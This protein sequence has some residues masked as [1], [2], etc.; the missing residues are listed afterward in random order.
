MKSVRSK[1]A[2]RFISSLSASLHP[3]IRRHLSFVCRGMGQTEA[4]RKIFYTRTRRWRQEIS[5]ADAYEDASDRTY[6]TWVGIT[7]AN[8]SVATA[9]RTFGSTVLDQGFDALFDDSD[10]W[11]RPIRV[12]KE[13]DGAIIW[14]LWGTGTVNL[15]ELWSSFVAG[16]KQEM[17]LCTDH[18][19]CTTDW[20]ENL[21]RISFV[22]V[23]HKPRK[24]SVRFRCVFKNHSCD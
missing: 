4:E 21:K 10:F 14:L 24:T 19:F 16:A 8:G 9:V 17:Q 20:R 2:E 5:K 6:T 7:C 12:P 15:S 23:C 11:P 3:L 22:K 13:G 1:L 18:C